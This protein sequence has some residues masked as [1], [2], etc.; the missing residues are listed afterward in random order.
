M[1]NIL[2][3][4]L[5]V[6]MLCT[7]CVSAISCNKQEQNDAQTPPTEDNNTPDNNTPDNNNPEDNNNPDDN[8]EPEIRYTVTEEEWEAL[9]IEKNYT[10]ERIENGESIT[11]QKYT[12][13]ALEIDGEDII[14]FIEDRQYELRETEDGWLAYDCTVLDFSHIGLLETFDFA[15][16][17]YSETEKAYIYKY[18]D[19][20]GVD[21]TLRFENG[22]PVSLTI[23]T[24][25]EPDTV[26]V[27]LMRDIG[28][29]VINIPDYEIF[30][31]PIAPPVS[32]ETWNSFA[33]LTNFTITNAIIG[34]VDSE[35]YMEA[36][37]ILS[38]GDALMVDDITIVLV[39]NKYYR[40]EETAD[41]WVA[42]ECE[43]PPF[44]FTTLFNGL[45]FNDF[46]YD[47]TDGL[48][49]ITPSSPGGIEYQVEFDL[50]GTPHRIYIF[51]VNMTGNPELD[52]CWLSAAFTIADIG[53]TVIDVPEYTIVE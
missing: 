9:V 53:N 43:L 42:S 50:D 7:V 24:D 29:T 47:E 41:G 22:L 35:F 17:E 44:C 25:E 28:T 31:E 45:N 13:D 33:G 46:T 48:Y 34:V 19:D 5:C 38:T 30:E 39:D 36:H 49:K 18:G 8:N 37:T 23:L 27:R 14:V 40:L 26:A 15:D 16:F 3:I 51:G 11:V 12:E 4:L 20:Y 6:A 21:L 52:D 1:K 32:E 10:L 2:A